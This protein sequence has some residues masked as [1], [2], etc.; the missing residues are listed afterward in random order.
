VA[1]A[2]L[3]PD[4]VFAVRGVSL[5]TF[6]S[7]ELVFHVSPAVPQAEID[8]IVA[9]ADDAVG[10][11]NRALAL[12]AFP[13]GPTRDVFVLDPASA[14]GAL[15]A[16]DPGHS[17]DVKAWT[18]R[19]FV[20]SPHEQ[21]RASAIFQWKKLPVSYLEI[22]G[23]YAHEWTHMVQRYTRGATPKEV[24][25]V[26][27]GEANYL[28]ALFQESVLPGA[29]TLFWDKDAVKLQR[30]R[31][32]RPTLTLNDLLTQQPHLYHSEISL[33]GYIARDLSPDALGRVRLAV[34]TDQIAYDLAW[35]RVIGRDLLDAGLADIAASPRLSPRPATGVTSP[36]LR[37]VRNEDVL[38]FVAAGFRP[39]EPV[40]RAV[41]VPSGRVDT[42]E[43]SADGRGVVAWS[44]RLHGGTRYTLR[45][46]K[47]S[48]ESG[49]CA[50]SYHDRQ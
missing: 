31:A 27:E 7:A 34:R 45:E 44:W 2:G 14:P 30:S 10:F 37:V 43:I 40:K 9:A 6:R 3:R 8:C 47:L 28:A 50:G 18:G 15:E 5:L 22:G 16:L 21:P 39:G 4:P 48:G 33:F 38:W 49:S 1:L 19:T 17:F 32:E 41:R 13:D 25:V 35:K 24:E 20:G 29:G 12:P 11:V 36:A 26:V 46:V 42:D 23:A